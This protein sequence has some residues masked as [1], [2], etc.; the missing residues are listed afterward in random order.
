MHI[1]LHLCDIVV[2]TVLASFLS[3][4]HLQCLLK[5]AWRQGRPGN[6]VSQY[7]CNVLIIFIALWSSFPIHLKLLLLFSGASNR[8]I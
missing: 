2:Q 4:S 6:E 1:Y 8:S 3:L 7:S 5:I